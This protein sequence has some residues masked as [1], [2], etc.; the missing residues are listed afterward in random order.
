MGHVIEH[1]HIPTQTANV[2]LRD[3][4]SPFDV[5][6]ELSAALPLDWTVDREVDPGG[7][8]S[9]IVFPTRDDL[10]R[11]AFVLYEDNGF[12]QVGIIS[13]ETWQGRRAFPS[14]QRAVAAIVAA[15]AYCV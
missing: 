2:W 7:D 9:I 6:A 14:C 1:K 5:V 12:V 8:I 4:V 13:G 3:V 10:E 15:A 11:S